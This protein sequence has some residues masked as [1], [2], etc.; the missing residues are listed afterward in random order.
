M[1]VYKRT[2]L[3]SILC[4]ESPSLRKRVNHEKVSFK[5]FTL[6]SQ[7]VLTFHLRRFSLRLL[8]FWSLYALQCSLSTAFSSF[9][10][11]NH[12]SGGGIVYSTVFF[13]LP[14]FA[15]RYIHRTE[16]W[17]ASAE[18]LL[19]VEFHS[20]NFFFNFAFFGELPMFKDLWTLAQIPLFCT[21]FK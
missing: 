6:M 14:I 3:P 7:I 20:K 13:V 11:P 10:V 4:E 1:R 17:V 5:K 8:C 21:H 2:G 16:L 12:Y 18:T 9:I 19:S 15:N